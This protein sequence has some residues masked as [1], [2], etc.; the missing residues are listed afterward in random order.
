MNII[1]VKV[2]T[3]VASEWD[4]DS[5]RAPADKPKYAREYAGELDFN[6]APFNFKFHPDTYQA[7]H[8][9]SRFNEN[10]E[11]PNHRFQVIGLDLETLEKVGTKLDFA[12]A[13]EIFNKHIADYKILSKEYEDK[14]RRKQLETSSI[15]LFRK[16]LEA[17]G[18]RVPTIESVLENGRCSSGM[19]AIKRLV[20]PFDPTDTDSIQISSSMGIWDINLCGDWHSRGRIKSAEKALAKAAEYESEW[21]AKKKCEKDSRDYKDDVKHHVMKIFGLKEIEVSEDSYRDYQNKYHSNGQKYTVANSMEGFYNGSVTLK[22]SKQKEGTYT[23]RIN[24]NVEFNEAEMIELVGLMAKSILRQ[25][26]ED[27]AEKEASK[28]A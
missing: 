14:E 8:G 21:L 19:D 4:S 7:L 11:V 15:N 24:P 2:K 22:A 20:N 17:A 18:F 16:S 28:K 25:D 23:Y 27:K 3:M 6:G 1:K 12:E 9:S 13:V 10:P 5:R 26:I